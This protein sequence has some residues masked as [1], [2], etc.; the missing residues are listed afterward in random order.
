MF[1]DCLSFTTF[2]PSIF[3]KNPGQNPGK[4]CHLAGTG[5][6][7]PIPVSAGA[8]YRDHGRFLD[9]YTIFIY[10]FITNLIEKVVYLQIYK[11]LME[12]N[13]VYLKIYHFLYF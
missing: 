4:I 7:S 10:Y 8:R 1:L 5:M 9:S 13:T 2:W 12:L 3:I 11:L 6:K